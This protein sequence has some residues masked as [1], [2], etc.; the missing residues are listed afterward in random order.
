MSRD[1]GAALPRGATGLSA[2]CDCGISRSYSL[3][4]FGAVILLGKIVSF[5]IISVYFSKTS[6]KDYF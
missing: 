4:T 2:V 1:G 5:Q 6:I 3:T